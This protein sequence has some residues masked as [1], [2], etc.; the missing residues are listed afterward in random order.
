VVSGGADAG[1]V[2]LELAEARAE[3]CCTAAS[4]KDS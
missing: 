3:I 1:D 2:L 4:R